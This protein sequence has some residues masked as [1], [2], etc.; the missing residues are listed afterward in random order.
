MKPEAKPEA[1]PKK[2]KQEPNRHL[3]AYPNR[4]AAKRRLIKD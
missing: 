3:P 4:F 2:V 1:K